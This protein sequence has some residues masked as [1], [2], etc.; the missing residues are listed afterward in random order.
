MTNDGSV[1]ECLFKNGAI[2]SNVSFLNWT[3][4]K[5]LIS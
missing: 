3:I 2:A 4:I 5:D 1:R